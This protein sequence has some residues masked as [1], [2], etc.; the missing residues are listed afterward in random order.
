[1]KKELSILG[2][3]PQ[4]R[5]EIAHTNPEMFVNVDP[6]VWDGLLWFVAR[7]FGWRQVT[8]G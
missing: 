4:S 6:R 8:A 1:M 2:G 3:N 5:E 7:A